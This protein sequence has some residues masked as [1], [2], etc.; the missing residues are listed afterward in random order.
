M[1]Y[2]WSFKGK[3]VWRYYSRGYTWTVDTIDV[4]MGIIV[5]YGVL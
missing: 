5:D 3:I 2:D 1:S 4:I